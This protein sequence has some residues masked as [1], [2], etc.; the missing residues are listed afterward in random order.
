VCLSALVGLKD[1]FGTKNS[2]ETTENLLCLIHVKFES[3]FH[4]IAVR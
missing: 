2:V 1:E 3:L 4:V